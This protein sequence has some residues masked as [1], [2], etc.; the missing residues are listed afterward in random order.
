MPLPAPPVRLPSYCSRPASETAQVALTTAQHAYHDRT[1]E[2]AAWSLVMLWQPRIG[3]LVAQ[4]IRRHPI[5]KPT[6]EDLRQDA[7]GHRRSRYA[8]TP[9][10]AWAGPVRPILIAKQG[11]RNADL[12]LGM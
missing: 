12:S 4:A 1:V 10:P 8:G 2:A 6:A 7:S 11:A 9:T 3:V 5:L